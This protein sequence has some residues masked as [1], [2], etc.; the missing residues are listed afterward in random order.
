MRQRRQ[1]DGKWSRARLDEWLDEYMSVD[2]WAPHA[3]VF[4][5]FLDK[6]G[7]RDALLRLVNDGFDLNALWEFYCLPSLLVQKRRRQT[8]PVF[9]RLKDKQ[10]SVHRKAK[11]L[12]KLLRSLGGP[13]GSP[14]P[15]L[16]CAKRR[17]CTLGEAVTIVEAIQDAFAASKRGKPKSWA[18]TLVSTELGLTQQVGRPA[19]R[20]ANIHQEMLEDECR[21]R[22]GRPHHEQVGILVAAIYDVP[23]ASQAA[24]ERQSRRLQGK[25]RDG[26]VPK[27]LKRFVQDDES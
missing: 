26:K 20:S 14:L 6:A 19:A 8:S 25:R 24:A 12:A 10:A 27:Y 2:P 22:T 21:Q 11:A 3:E 16:P 13:G 7:I 17:P 5:E 15:S 23:R 9:R 1:I 18:N 4:R